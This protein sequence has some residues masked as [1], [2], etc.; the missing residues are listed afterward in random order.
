MHIRTKLLLSVILLAIALLVSLLALAFLAHAIPSSLRKA[1]DVTIR[2]QIVALEMHAQLRDAEAAL[3]RY[4]MEGEPGYAEQFNHHLS[5]FAKE[6][7]TYQSLTDDNLETSWAE[8]LRMSYQNAERI[9]KTLIQLRDAQTRDLQSLEA[10]QSVAMRLLSGPIAANH[11]SNVVYQR[12]VTSME[13][14]IREMALIVMSSLTTSKEAKMVRLSDATVNLQQQYIQYSAMATTAQE[15]R[16]AQSLYKA[17]S[18][19]QSISLQI[20]NER[21]EQLSLFANFAA[22]LFHMSQE[23][24]AQKIQPQST[25]RLSLAWQNLSSTIN[26]L[27]LISLLVA[28]TVSIPVTTVTALTLRQINTGI[29]ALLGGADRVAEGKLD[30]PVKVKGRDELAQLAN[31]FNSMMNELL[32]REFRLKA[33][34]SELEALRN[35]G[36]QLTS[37][38]E[39]GKV[40]DTIASSALRLVHAF[41]VHIF[42]YK[43]ES[44]SLEFIVSALSSQVDHPTEPAPAPDNLVTTVVRTREYKV[45]NKRNTSRHLTKSSAP[46]AK[47]QAAAGFP[48]KQE[49]HVAGVLYVKLSDRSTFS[50]DDLRILGLLADQAAIALV[51][52]HLYQKLSDKEVRLRLLIQK[53]SHVQEEERRLLG[54]DLHDSLMQ[55]LISSNMHLNALE[56][57]ETDIGE[58]VK[59][60][61]AQAHDRISE[62]IEE[63]RRIVAEL[64][65]AQIED[66][67]LID[68]L[69]QYAAAV[70]Q[71]EG[72]Q[73]EF[74]ANLSVPLEIPS[75][76]ETAIFR[77]A[78]EALTNARKHAHTDRIRIL[79]QSTESR[80]NLEVQDWGCGFD[81][82]ILVDESTH[83]GIVGMQERTALINGN[84]YIESRPGKGTLVRVSVPTTHFEIVEET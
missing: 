33:R 72:W 81:K 56:T 5:A 73:L 35:V 25:L 8:Q 16:L 31:T 65:P 48:L 26:L 27:M 32:R 4:L 23:I 7:D 42:L 19:I 22:I 29:A 57:I 47:I 37:T 75:F 1:E 55:L 77:I 61:I 10:A 18:D 40:L 12:N 79:L 80:L 39:P 69:R 64:R 9:G 62:A 14:S 34:I 2:E 49:G 44:D 76:A 74:S 38:L 78:Q 13:K 68:G 83:L 6:L 70:A 58:P 21:D 54:L 67:S 46:A 71:R 30:E 59:K 28:I 24:L 63:S 43:E 53:L 17:F 60:E 3:Y 15:Q 52:A 45:V 51:N 36:L 66:L 11:V 84:F 50:S 41:E 82:N 20:V